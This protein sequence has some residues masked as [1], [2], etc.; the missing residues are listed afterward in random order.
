[1]LPRHFAGEL[2][3]LMS[4]FPAV[5][6]LGPRQ[7]GKTTF[8]RAELPGWTY[9]DLERP[10][11]VAPLAADPA[12]RL[13]Q[14]GR[15]VILD[16]A[17]RLP[18][19]FPVLRGLIDGQESRRARYLLLG[20]A[21]PSLVSGISETLAGRTGFLELPPFRWD[22]V[23]GRRPAPDLEALWFRGGFPLAFLERDDRSRHD[24]LDAYLRTFVERDL[25]ALGVD[26]SPSRMRSLCT[27]LA[28]VHGTTWNASRL[29]SSLGVSYHT[30]NRYLDILEQGFIVRRLPPWFANVGKRLVKSPKVYLRDTGLLHSLLGIGDAKALHVH[31]S[32]GASWEGFVIEHV[33]SALQRH[34]PAARAHFWR[35]A[36]GDEVDLLVDLGPRR[37]PFE[38]KLHS[39]PKAE[40]AGGVR[41]CMEALGLKRGYVL[42]AGREEYSLGD[43]IRAVPAEHL[44]R[45]PRAVSRL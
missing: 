8:V 18:E 42:H 36:T 3:R 5:T 29:A 12:A 1:M 22:E 24:W 19:I 28:H 25:T 43:G 2:R 11:D 17:Q 20:S 45:E 9:V 38:I 13:L 37:V 23:A 6:V 34:A 16:E 21:A 32:R 15:A 39:A 27:M 35:T 30:V 4:R 10:S 26:A 41:R 14:L 44:L 40:D 7:C 33:L 31:P